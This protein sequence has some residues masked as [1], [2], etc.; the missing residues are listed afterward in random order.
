VSIDRFALYERAVQNPAHEVKLF[1]RAFKAARGREATTLR[2]DF[3]GSAAVSA[4]WAR[5]DVARR[6]WA[7]DHDAAALAWCREHHLASLDEATRARVVLLEGDVRTTDSPAVDVIAAENFSY[8]N[9]HTREELRTYFEC[10]REN[11]VPD[12]ALFLDVQGG[13]ATQRERFKER[14]VLDGFTMEWEHQ[15]FDP[16]THR[17]RFAM[18]FEQDGAREEDAFTYD[19]RL[20]TLP[21]LKELLAEAGFESVQLWWPH[22][23]GAK[24]GQYRRREEAPASELWVAYLVA[25]K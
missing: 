11:L 9:F 15:R 17:V 1:S 10:A 23:D 12:G 19:W 13:P 3:S 24:R 14:R 8:C 4:A 2:E 22:D 7:I 25:F 5:S 21:E 6:A 20:W 18:H 16:L